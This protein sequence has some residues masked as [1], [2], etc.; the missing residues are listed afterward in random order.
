MKRRFDYNKQYEAL[1]REI[2]LHLRELSRIPN[3]TVIPAAGL[4]AWMA[5]NQIPARF[6]WCWFIAVVFPVLGALRSRAIS[7]KIQLIGAY[8]RR[9]EKKV[10]RIG[11]PGWETSIR[12]MLDSRNSASSSKHENQAQWWRDANPHWYSGLDRTGWLLWSLF[13][14]VSLAIGFLEVF[15]P[16]K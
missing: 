16:V 12:T 9:F 2:E 1:R 6:R 8:L 10:A 13:F 4:W 15:S 11:I 5:K 14:A 7:R 3:Y